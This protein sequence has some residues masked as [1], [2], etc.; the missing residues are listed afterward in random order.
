MP[1]FFFDIDDQRDTERLDLA[2]EIVARREIMK[3]LPA[4]AAAEG[5]FGG[6]IPKLDVHDPQWR[7]EAGLPRPS[8]PSRR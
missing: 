6:V 1:R 2:S 5:V 4:I 7:W 3:A 8:C